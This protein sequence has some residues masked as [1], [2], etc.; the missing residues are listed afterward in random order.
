[1]YLNPEE[2]PFSRPPPQP[3]RNLAGAYQ[4]Q[5]DAQLFANYNTE[6]SSS[7]LISRKNRRTPRAEHYSRNARH[8]AFAGSTYKT[9]PSKA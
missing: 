9:G 3:Y 2:L 6:V 8:N 1:M 4:A 7:A 5:R